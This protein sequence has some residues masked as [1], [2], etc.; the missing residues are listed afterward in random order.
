VAALVLRQ[1]RLDTGDHL[2]A[3]A[4]HT[5]VVVLKK[6]AAFIIGVF[7]AASMLM[8]F[9]STRQFGTSI[10]VAGGIV[11]LVVGVA[12][13]RSLATLL[14]GFQAALT[15][16]IRIHDMVNIEGEWGRIE[17]ITLTYVVVRLSD[18]RRLVVPITHFSERPFQNWSRAAAEMVGVVHLH[19]DYRAPLDALRA[20]LTRILR[21]SPHWDGRVNALEVTDARA[22]TL[23]IRA[24]ASAADPARAWGLRCEIRERLV[25]FL[26]RE[27]PEC[28]PAGRADLG[29]SMP[30]SAR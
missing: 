13:Q 17:D 23:E 1:H 27:F 11:S 5:Q 24:L 25:E 29:D 22:H 7:T 10:L 6:V 19:V 12:A 20:E 8:V 18:D 14:A 9:E 4:V 26:Q 15:Q 3:S 28:L 30:A 21:E 2:Q 16:P